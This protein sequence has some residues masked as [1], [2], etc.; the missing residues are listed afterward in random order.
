MLEKFHFHSEATGADITIPWIHN[1]I[2]AGWLR[3]NRKTDPEER[4]WAMLEKVAD[5]ET[6]AAVDNLPMGEFQEFMGAWQAGPE[7]DTSVGESSDS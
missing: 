4:G 7:G 6:L 2:T 1:A 3:K 5:E